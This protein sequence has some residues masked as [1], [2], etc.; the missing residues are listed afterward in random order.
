M[1]FFR[2]RVAAPPVTREEWVAAAA[3]LTAEA[4]ADAKAMKKWQKGRNTHR[5]SGGFYT[6]LGIDH[7]IGGGHGG[8]H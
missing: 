4:R 8:H 1:K 7:G 6:G 2:R 3:A 5:A